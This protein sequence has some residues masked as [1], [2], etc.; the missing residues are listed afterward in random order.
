M[1]ITLKWPIPNLVL[2]AS[3]QSARIAA[4]LENGDLVVWRSSGIDTSAAAVIY[5]A[6]NETMVH[7]DADVLIRTVLD[8]GDSIAIAGSHPLHRLRLMEQLAA[9]RDTERMLCLEGRPLLRRQSSS[10]VHFDGHADIGHASPLERLLAD[11]GCFQ[12]DRA[13]LRASVWRD[14]PAIFQFAAMGV[15]LIA[16]IPLGSAGDM[17]TCLRT[18]LASSSV[19]GNSLEIFGKTFRLLIICSGGRSEGHVEKILQ[20]ENREDGSLKL[21]VVFESNT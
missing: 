4:C 7:P 10:H 2:K 17:E 16:E 11:A 20:S 5:R 19:T 18:G 1:V 8:R 13:I 12:A 3:C 21:A 9:E 15:P 14:A 6:T